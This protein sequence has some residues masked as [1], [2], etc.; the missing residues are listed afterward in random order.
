MIDCSAGLD[1]AL[2]GL[3]WSLWA[4]LG[5]SG[6]GRRHA[7]WEVDPEALIVFTAALGNGDPRLRD[8]S[9][10][11]CIQN[12]RYVSAVRLRNL[13]RGEPPRVRAAFGP[14]AATVRA[15]ARVNWPTTDAPWP[16]DRTGKSRLSDLTRP[17]LTTLRHRALFGTSARAEIIRAFSASPHQALTAATLAEGAHYT[18]RNVEQEL[19]SLRLAG[20]LAGTTIRGQLYYRLARAEALLAFTGARPDHSPRWDRVFRVLLD[21][22]SLRTQ[23]D[24]LDPRVRAVEASKLVRGLEPDL[25]RAGLMP[26]AHVADPGA[27]DAFDTWIRATASRLASGDASVLA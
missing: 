4:E 11:W 25:F 7:D 19:H 27:W 5:V 16:Y 6:W 3:A 1:D 24:R 18:K 12:H 20:L 26:P 9:L 15:H 8:E 10:D 17:S 13:L 2:R 23:A 22:L 21:G 14:Y